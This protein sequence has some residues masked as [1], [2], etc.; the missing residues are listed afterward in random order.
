V[1]RDD[2]DRPGIQVLN[3]GGYANADVLLVPTAAG[4]VVVKDY[5]RRSW[6]VRR[7]IAPLLVHH[8]H[9]MLRRAAGLPG[10][11][12]WSERIDR[13]AL[14]MQYIEGRSLR[15]RLNRPGLPASFFDALEAVLEGLAHRGLLH[16]DLRSPTNVLVSD[17]DAPAVIDLAAAFAV[18][19][20][21][22]VRRWLERRALRKLRRRIGVSTDEGSDPGDPSTLASPSARAPVFEEGG[23]DLIVNRVRYRRYEEGS[24][25]DPVPALLLPDVGVGA[26][27]Y[28]RVLEQAGASGRRAIALDLPGS[29]ASGPGRGRRTPKR[30]AAE[31]GALLEILRL[32]R[33][34]VFG[35]GL[36]GVFARSLALERPHLVRALVTLD[37][38]VLRLGPALQERVEVALS[39]PSG[40]P[41]LLLS[42]NILDVP[43]FSGDELRRALAWHPAREF[44]RPLRALPLRVGSGDA[45]ELDPDRLGTPA[46]PWLALFSRSDDPGHADVHKVPGVR[47]VTWDAGLTRPEVFWQALE[48]FVKDSQGAPQER[49]RSRDP[50]RNPG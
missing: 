15:R 10:L 1:T 22:P 49:P 13:L 30:L 23:L 44:A 43:G 32:S 26:R 25:D 17:T 39:D 33:V 19:L 20:P 46:V 36:G 37:A 18:P 21:V 47:A 31:L 2:L 24:V 14:C 16:L 9:A 11:P 40:L 7:W 8:E 48:E 34:D 28:A 50:V 29:G 4:R 6:A 45:P 42:A 3:Q 38:P 5:V 41:S 35:L 27:A 12:A